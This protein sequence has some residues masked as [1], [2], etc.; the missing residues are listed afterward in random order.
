MYFILYLN[1]HLKLFCKPF[2][3]SLFFEN[4]LNGYIVRHHIQSFSYY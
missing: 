1:V 2:P 4:I 3:K